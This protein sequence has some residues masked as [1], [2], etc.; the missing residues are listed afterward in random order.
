MSRRRVHC[1]GSSAL[2]SGTR[3]RRLLAR[4][5]GTG[6][7]VAEK[8]ARGAVWAFAGY[9]VSRMLGFASSIVLAR[10]LSPGDLGLMGLVGVVTAAIYAL[11]VVGV[12][13]AL[14]HTRV[15]TDDLLH[16]AWTL[17]LVRGGLLAA[18]VLAVAPL[19]AS[20]FA[21]PA[22][23]LLLRVMSVVFLA[24]GSANVGMT[25]LRKQL[26]FRTV[27]RAGAAVGVVGLA[28]TV[29][30]AVLLRNVWALVIGAI[31]QSIAQL[32]VSYVVHP[33]RP[34]I[35]WDWGAAR[36]LLDYGKSVMA[37]GVVYYLLTQGDD[38]LVGRVLGTPALGLYG[39]AYRLSNTPATGLSQ[40]VSL[41]TFPAYAQMRDDLPALRSS[42]LNTLRFVSLLAVPLSGGLLALAPEIVA[43]LYGSKWLPMV[44][45]FTVLCLF[46]LERA[47]GS[48]SGPVFLAVGKP[49]T[50]LRLN[51][52]KLAAM[53]VLIFP[54][55]AKYGRLGT[56]IAVT[57]SAVVVALTVLPTVAR[58]LKCDVSIILR[59]LRPSFLGALLMVLGLL[60]LKR[61]WVHP[62]SPAALASLVVAGA[63]VYGVLVFCTQP[64]LFE[65][66]RAFVA[67]LGGPQAAGR[68]DGMAEDV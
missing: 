3:A 43:V 36:R 61:A 40:V 53:G 34:R 66:T 20:F 58:E 2:L 42:Y 33:F 23:K 54:R 50:L 22:L 7:S 26:D 48:T 47:I 67:S 16:V 31:A 52:A 25:L 39:L 46:G 19:L 63:L 6:G 29:A 68:Q 45:A 14:I 41:V 35:R 37:S 55:T 51:L 65:M 1:A 4:L 28:V 24:D 62:A 17:S 59:T 32:V 13:P 57:G 12:A 27:A 9:G 44:P 11:T 10:L 56:S 5:R 8:M 21:E 15:L 38:A 60:L 49:Q 64:E 30:A 18:L